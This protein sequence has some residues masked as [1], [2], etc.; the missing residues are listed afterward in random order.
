M[1]YSINKALK[2]NKLHKRYPVY[3]LQENSSLTIVLPSGMRLKIMDMDRHSSITVNN[4]QKSNFTT[5]VQEETNQLNNDV[6]V[7]KVRITHQNY[8]DCLNADGTML[9]IELNNFI[10]K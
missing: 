9:S 10:E 3:E 7:E 4:F 5:H 2:S 1:N 8:A 6:E